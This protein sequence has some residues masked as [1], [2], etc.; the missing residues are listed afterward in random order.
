MVSGQPGPEVL[1]KTL[2]GIIVVGFKKEFIEIDFPSRRTDV[3]GIRPMCRLRVTGTKHF[4]DDGLTVSSASTSR[5]E[6]APCSETKLK[7]FKSPVEQ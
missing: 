1:G 3:S 7:V 6:E 5:G 2:F 4:N